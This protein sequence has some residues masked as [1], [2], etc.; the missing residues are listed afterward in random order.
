MLKPRKSFPRRISSKQSRLGATMDL[1]GEARRTS[2]SSLFDLIHGYVYGRWPYLYIATGIG[3]NR[4]ARI[5]SPI[6]GFVSMLVPERSSADG[7]T[8]TVADSY[9]GKVMPTETARRLVSLDTPIDLRDLEQVVPFERAR[10]II[11]RHPDH[12]VALQ[13]P[14]RSAR[15]DP[16]LPLDVCLIVGEPFAGFVAAHHPGRSRWVSQREAQDILRAE[17]DRGHVHHAF[18]KD[19]MLDRFYAICNCCDCCCGAMQAMRNGSPMLIS[20]GYVTQV[21]ETH[22]MLCGLCADDCP[23][24]ALSLGDSRVEVSEALCMGCGICVNNCPEG[25]LQLE[26]DPSKPEPLVIPGA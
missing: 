10:E 22:C 21:D 11:L 7:E 17:R 26:R 15:S 19:A 23:F 2:N 9:H 12:I 18:F 13:C 20:S 8:G 4:L 6:I 14:C 1:L 16:C 3:E 5:L 25:A 24:G